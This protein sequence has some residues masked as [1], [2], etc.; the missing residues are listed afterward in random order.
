MTFILMFLS[1]SP[2]VSCG[3]NASD[4]FPIKSLANG[5]LIVY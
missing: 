3:I 2:A 5:V 4:L 1:L